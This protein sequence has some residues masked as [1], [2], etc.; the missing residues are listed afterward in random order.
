MI[1]PEHILP[2]PRIKVTRRSECIPVRC[3]NTFLFSVGRRFYSKK[4]SERVAKGKMEMGHPDIEAVKALAEQTRV[5]FLNMSLDDQAKAVL[6]SKLY[7]VQFIARR[8]A[9][10]DIKYEARKVGCSFR[11]N[12]KRF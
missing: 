11:A 12:S 6:S 9:E 10:K 2:V 4:L 5:L 7:R 8:S 3:G 1:N